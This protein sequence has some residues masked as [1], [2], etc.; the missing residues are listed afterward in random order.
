M[1]AKLIGIGGGP[2]VDP[3]VAS[4]GPSQ[5][6]QSLTE[7]CDASLTFRIVC[8]GAYEDP[9]EP[10]PLALLRPRRERPRRRATEQRDEITS[11][12]HSITSSARA[13]RFGGRVRPSAA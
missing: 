1:S 11:P 8:R 6:L 9:D 10:Y 12:H 2:N 3:Y 7:G 13:S 4:L 5:F